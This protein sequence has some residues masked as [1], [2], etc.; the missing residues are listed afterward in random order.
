MIK[1]LKGHNTKKY[2][3]KIKLIVKNYQLYLIFLPVL[4]Y[5]LI[6]HYGPMYGIQ[7][8][9]KD[10]S[11]ARG[12]WGSKWVGLENF[13]RFFRSHYFTKLIWNTLSISLYSLIVN[14]PIPI[15]LA[16]M[17]NE[18]KNM[19]FKKLV[20]TVS[21]APHFIS[22]VVMAG[23]IILFLSP[24]SGIINQIIVFFGKE[25]VNFMYE[26]KYFKTIYVFS[27]LWQ[28]AG[29]S[30]II[31]LSAL[32]TID[33]QQHEA[34]VIDGAKRLQR[35][36]YINVPGILPT[37]SIMLV[38]AFGN[39]MNVGFEKVFLLTNQLNRSSADVISTF[40]YRVGLIDHDYSFSTAVGLFNSVINLMLL[41]TVNKITGKL[42][43]TT[44]F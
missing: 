17:L 37:I 20:Q 30:S 11:G 39:I 42:D 43:Q 31:Y 8:A 40:V 7:I 9:F 38:L 14:F 4:A 12:I 23:M 32:S 22:T 29:W 44:L 33:P 16:L 41:L 35:I 21:Y 13:Q 5:Y 6:F 2:N 10:F 36:W 25:P 19:K 26:A 34:A 27:G 24:Q 15:V 1:I 3:K 28:N 18:V